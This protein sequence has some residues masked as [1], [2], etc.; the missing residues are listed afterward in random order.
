MA[1][2]RS[3]LVLVAVGAALLLAAGLTGA[4]VTTGAM[5]ATPAPDSDAQGVTVTGAGSA[6]GTPDV[7]RFTVGV[8]V[9]APSVDAAL[10]S[11]NT[12]Q[13]RVLAVL[14]SAGTAG[15]DVQTTDVR[16]EPRYDAKGQ[17][18]TGYLVHEDVRVEVREL[19][20]AGATISAAVAAG[21]DAARLSGV[22]FVLEDD[23][24]LR[25]QA[26]QQAFA[27]AKAKAEQYAELTGRELGAVQTVVEDVRP[28]S[29]PYA[30]ESTFDTAAAAVPLAPGSAEVGVDVQV[31]WSL[32]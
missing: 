19:A 27:A 2:S 14:E 31:R 17:R 23:E 9:A 16:V 10:A 13:A 25:V 8:Q 24:A 3:S 32:R 4:A 15:R 22:Q 20:T 12:A 11:A 29:Q 18:I 7:L 6:S 21:G 26:R 30:S 5:A 1:R 28:T